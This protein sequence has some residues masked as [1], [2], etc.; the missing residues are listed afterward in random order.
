MR[1]CVLAPDVP[2]PANRGGRVDVMRR[3]QAMRDLGHEVLLV[4]PTA[5][6]EP[7]ADDDAA[8]RYFDAIQ[9]DW[10]ALPMRGA[11]AAL[12][13]V[14]A[15]GGR[16]PFFISR[17][18]PAG[19]DFVTLLEQVRAFAPS[20]LWLEGPWYWPLA[21]RLSRALGCRV[22]YRSHNIEHRYMR[23]QA[24]LTRSGLARL[25]MRLSF[26]GLHALEHEAVGA[27]DAL[28]DISLD[29]LRWWNVPHGHW[30]PP[31][32]ARKPAPETKAIAHD[33]IVF[34]GNLTTPNNIAGVRWLVDEVMPQ[35]SARRPDLR[36]RV[37]GSNPA[38]ELVAHVE[39]R[40]GLVSSNVDDPFAYMAR[41]GVLVNP[42]FAGSGV[43]LKMLDMLMTDRPIVTAEQ[44][45]RG[46]PEQF[47]SQ[48]LLG[49]SAAEF[50]T[51]I[52]AAIEGGGA[53]DLRARAELR[54][55]FDSRAVDDALNCCLAAS[56]RNQE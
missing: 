11:A 35:V 36:L 47:R 44:G 54:R 10:I 22:A 32:S 31:L 39:A 9:I 14:F 40:G 33:E 46:L 49:D 25:K 4:T 23:G 41:A 52:I 17:R 18:Q 50:A 21:R 55:M 29:D 5:R 53:V 26:V 56:P 45:L 27:A 43:Q 12:A 8:R 51:E 24:A 15:H 2:Y 19:A 34:V 38:A 3:L 7:N 16:L 6:H 42:V 48:V 37:V 13:G 1:V 30:L 20:V 28:F